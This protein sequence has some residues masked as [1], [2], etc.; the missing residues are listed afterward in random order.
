MNIADLDIF[1]DENRETEYQLAI[2]EILEK[3]EKIEKIEK[4]Y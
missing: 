4:T 2:M 3:I 1:T